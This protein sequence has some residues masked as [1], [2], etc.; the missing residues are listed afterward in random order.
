[1]YR[2]VAQWQVSRH[3]SGKAYFAFLLVRGF[4]PGFDYILVGP[5]A[6]VEVDGKGVFLVLECDGG[7][8]RAVGISSG[9]YRAYGHVQ[10]H[11][12]VGVYGGKSGFF[13]GP[14]AVHGVCVEARSA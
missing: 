5:A 11:V 7:D 13:L 10:S 12:A 14:Q 1:M 4:G 6:V 8:G 3:K 2:A 9:A